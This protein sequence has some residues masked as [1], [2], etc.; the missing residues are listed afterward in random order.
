M[1]QIETFKQLWVALRADPR[2]CDALLVGDGSGSRADCP[3]GWAL[4]II[5]MN[6]ELQKP[7]RGTLLVGAQTQASINYLEAITYW[8]GLRHLHYAWGWQEQVSPKKPKFV[9]IVTDSEWTAKTMSGENR[10]KQHLDLKMLYDL[11]RSW[12]YLLYWFH[13][14]RERIN[15]NSL[16][17]LMSSAAREYM[18]MLEPV[19]PL[20]IMKEE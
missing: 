5:E 16:A 15:L 1:E 10:A 2:Y 3:G 7:T 11:Y 4:S 19:N 18:L 20:D 13:A 17:D 12:G 9:Y 6:R 8:Y 14:P